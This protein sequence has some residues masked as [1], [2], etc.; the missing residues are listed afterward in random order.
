MILFGLIGRPVTHSAGQVMYNRLFSDLKMNAAYLAMDVHSEVLGTAVKALGQHF[1]GFNVTIPHK[2][3][4]M[5][6][7]DRKDDS[8]VKAGNVNLVIANDNEM[9]GYNTDYTALLACMRDKSP[10]FSPKNVLIFGSGGTA[11]TAIGV[12]QNEFDPETVRVVS[13]TPSEAAGRLGMFP[14]EKTGIISYDDVAALDNIDMIINCTP[15]GMEKAGT[16][17]LPRPGVSRKTLCVADFVYTPATTDLT[18]WAEGK[19]ACVI[20]GD[21]IF[22]RQ[23]AGTL[24]IAFGLDGT[25]DALR[26]LL[27]NIQ[28]EKSGA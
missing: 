28:E 11:R 5:A 22:I 27:R 6:Y 12:L 16:S 25:E 18:A 19:G 1:R 7:L 3:A 14:Q 10:G 17:V 4:V 2:T 15:A 23:A 8:A 26:S 20:R 24:S 13:R 21:E 9:C